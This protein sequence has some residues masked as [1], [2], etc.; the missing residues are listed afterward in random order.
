LLKSILSNTIIDQLL[1]K[2]TGS[3]IDLIILS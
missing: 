2:L 3:D 1:I